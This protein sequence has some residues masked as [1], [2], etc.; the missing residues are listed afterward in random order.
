VVIKSDNPIFAVVVASAL[1]AKAS[2]AEVGLVHT[3]K[4]ET[5]DHARDL[6]T[7]LVK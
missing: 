6:V 2:G 4:C 1:S 5:I 7:L 3:G